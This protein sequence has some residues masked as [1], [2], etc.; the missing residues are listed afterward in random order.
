[1]PF[2]QFAITIT[3]TTQSFPLM[4]AIKLL[5]DILDTVNWTIIIIISN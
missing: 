2:L 3:L 1:M 5:H 4:D